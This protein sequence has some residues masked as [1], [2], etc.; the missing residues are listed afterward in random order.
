MA[1]YSIK[2]VMQQ[3]KTDPPM[4]SF[5]WRVELPDL[6]LGINNDSFSINSD[7]VDSI[8]EL[9]K[10]D[11]TIHTTLSKRVSTISIPFVTIETDKSII[12]N[13]YWYYGKQN[14][15]GSISFE[16]LEY[17]DGLSYKFMDTWK[18]LMVNPNGTYNPPVAYKRDVKFY[19]LNSTKSDIIIHT[20]KGYF[21]SGIA[22]I[23]ND[24][25][26]NEIV[27]FSINLTGDEV[28]TERFPIA[29]IVNDPNMLEQLKSVLSLESILPTL[30]TALDGKFKNATGLNLPTIF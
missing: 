16:I 22:D 17:E 27:K 15:I 18:S 28:S 21:V 26:T 23:N 30:E 8:D 20:Y 4:K 25:E 9:Y 1:K 5:L 13:S 10:I 24:Y 19:R 29:G 11:Q 14:D 2:D 12:G 6:S 7:A 3:F